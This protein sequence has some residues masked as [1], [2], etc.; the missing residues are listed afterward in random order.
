[1]M[2]KPG[3]LMFAAQNATMTEFA[4]ALQQAVLDRPVVDGTGLEDRYDFKLSFAPIGTEF[5]GN[6]RAPTTEEPIAPS[7][8]TAMQELGLKIDSVKTAVTVL[9]VDR[10]EKPTGN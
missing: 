4:M 7:L 5:G 2:A 9:V 1:M 10:V 6:L 3:M 8:F